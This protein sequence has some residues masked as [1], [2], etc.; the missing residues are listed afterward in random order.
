MLRSENCPI[1]FELFQPKDYL[2]IGPRLLES[3]LKKA[4]KVNNLRLLRHNDHTICDNVTIYHMKYFSPIH[5]ERPE[6]YME[7]NKGKNFVSK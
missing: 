6:K 7:E 3:T 2:T 5:T 4:C 1:S